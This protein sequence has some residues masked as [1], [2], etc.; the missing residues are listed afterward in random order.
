MFQHLKNRFLFTATALVCLIVL[1]LFYVTQSPRH[2][3]LTFR[4]MQH[5]CEVTSHVADGKTIVIFD[6]D[7]TLVCPK[8][9]LGSDQWFFKIVD[10]ATARGISTHDAIEELVPLYYHIH[11]HID[12]QPVEPDTIDVLRQLKNRNAP[13]IA[14]TARRAPNA[15]RTHEQLR[16]AGIQL[17]PPAQMLTRMIIH[18]KEPALLLDGIIFCGNNDKGSALEQVFAQCGIPLPERIVYVDDKRS[19]LDAVA[20]FCKKSGI[21]YI[22]LRYGY[23]DAAV[24][25]YDVKKADKQLHEFLKKHPFK[26]ET[27]LVISGSVPDTQALSKRQHTLVRTLG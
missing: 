16:N 5:V 8:Q 18:T 13:V 2:F 24:K 11:Q 6:L 25:A 22:G 10:N 19:H 17:N 3:S 15:E 9:E 7:N 1:A 4:E 12:L 14:L 20:R 26:L 27:T 21:E 23:L